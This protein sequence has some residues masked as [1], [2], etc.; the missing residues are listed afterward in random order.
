MRQLEMPLKHW[1]G[2]RKR[3]GR[4]PVGLRSCV[5]RI[6]RPKLHDQLPVHV[7]L[8]VLT[9]IPNLR[10]MAAP[11]TRALHAGAER[12][13]FRLLHYSIQDNHLHLIA[14]A[15][16]ARSFSRGM[17]GLAIRIAR[18][19]NRALSR[20]R[21]KVFSD[22]YHQRLLKTP[23]QARHA[24]V[25]VI[26]N[27]KKHKRGLPARFIDH[28]H[29][30]ARYFARSGIAAPSSWLMRGG[31]KRAGDIELAT[32]VPRSDRADRRWRDLDA[33]PDALASSERSAS[34]QRR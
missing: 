27:F 19:V 24:L 30:S 21:G 29:S 15:D 34:R 23:T 25:Y 9:D 1:G 10:V 12:Y 11:I 13:R 7:T 20:K 3:S 31:W 17:Q 33:G 5:R 32:A 6:K 18:A 8:R 16:D 4:K 2:K 26:N 14:E 28:N 22:R